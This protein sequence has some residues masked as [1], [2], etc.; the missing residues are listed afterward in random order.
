[1]ITIGDYYGNTLK[2]GIK[3]AF[4]YQGQ[5]RKGTVVSVKERTQNGHSKD[6][7]TGRRYVTIEVRHYLE[8]TVS[9]V[10]DNRNVTVIA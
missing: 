1:M 7:Y 8:N 2:P 3:V 5:V 9:K 10:S 6:P 4:N